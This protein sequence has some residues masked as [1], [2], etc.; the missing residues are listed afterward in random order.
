M[1]S[2]ERIL[3]ASV[4]YR[5]SQALLSAIELGLFTELAKGP[6]SA[7]QLCHALGVSPRTTPPWLDTLVALGF[8]DRDGEGE[9]AIYLNTRETSHFLD[10]NAASYIGGPLES[11]G[12][13][14]FAGWDA[15]LEALRSGKDGISWGAPPVES[16]R[17]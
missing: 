7:N 15:L 16:E 6:R 14:I 9:C 8:L 5:A 13:R 4:G 11:A 2:P 1:L 12:R 10:R 17:S 3:Q